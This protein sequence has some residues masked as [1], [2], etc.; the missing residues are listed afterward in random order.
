MFPTD[1]NDFLVTKWD[2]INIHDRRSISNGKLKFKSP[3]ET[4]SLVYNVNEMSI[5]LRAL[6]ELR[7]S[8]LR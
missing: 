4:E 3:L 5:G 7:S 8:Y 6:D 2:S 1:V